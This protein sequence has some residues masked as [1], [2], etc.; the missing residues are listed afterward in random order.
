M[1]LSCISFFQQFKSPLIYILFVAALFA[2]ALGKKGDSLVILIVVFINAL[3]GWFQ[4]G[5][6]EKAMESLR[7]LSSP[8]ARVT[9]ISRGHAGV[10]LKTVRQRHTPSGSLRI[11]SRSAAI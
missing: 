6:A 8:S 2:F 7:K 11:L 9:S 1:P 3:I 4:E 5:R 10:Q